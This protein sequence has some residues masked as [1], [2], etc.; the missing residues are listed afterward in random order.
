[1]VSGSAPAHEVL[2]QLVQPRPVL[3]ALGEQDVTVVAVLADGA[4]VLGDMLVVVAAEA[5]HVVE[6]A[7]G[8][9]MRQVAGIGAPLDVHLREDVA[10]EDDGERRCRALQVLLQ[11][12][13]VFRV[14][15]AVIYGVSPLS[16]ERRTEPAA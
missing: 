7:L 16:G 14:V 3:L 9:E 4:A 1:M 8:V 6:L 15:L 10:L 11:A 5:A 12:G 2:A 13:Q